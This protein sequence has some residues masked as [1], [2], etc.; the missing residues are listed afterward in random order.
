M[1]SMPH[2]DA[3][4]SD[5]AREFLEAP[6]F[7]SVA[8]ID[9]DGAPRQT[10]VWYAL[11]ADGRILINGR[12]PRRWCANLLRDP[13]VA[14]SVVDGADGYR[15]LGIKGVVDEVIQDIEPARDD[16]VALAHRY[17]PEGADEKML[18]EFR[19]QPRITYLVRATGVYEHLGD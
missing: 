6:R 16:I 11:R 8:T 5:T 17:Y 9:D 15:W 18:A 1:A 13:R 19:T 3:P 12:L 10:V 4:L 14:I 7:A 2:T